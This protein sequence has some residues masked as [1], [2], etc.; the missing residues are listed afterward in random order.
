M[1]RRMFVGLAGAA[2]CATSKFTTETRA[3]SKPPDVTRMLDVTRVPWVAVAGIKEAGP[4]QLFAGVGR[5]GGPAV[6]AS[7]IFPAAGWAPGWGVDRSFKIPSLFHWGD[8]P[9]FKNFC[10]IQPAKKSAL[11]FF[12]NGDSGAALYAWL[13]RQLLNEDPSAFYWI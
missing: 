12:T 2:V 13:F 5:A 7:T 11:V 1:N 9:G 8:G 10:W 3:E 4:Y 6:T